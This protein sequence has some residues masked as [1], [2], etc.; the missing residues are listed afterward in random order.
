MKSNTT[1]RKAALFDL[2]DQ[3]IL[4]N[5]I[6]FEFVIVFDIDHFL[7]ILKSKKKQIVLDGEISITCNFLE[8]SIDIFLANY[9]YFFVIVRAVKMNTF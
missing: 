3:P 9:L 7:I 2:L 4:F 6:S 8:L 5:F 1:I